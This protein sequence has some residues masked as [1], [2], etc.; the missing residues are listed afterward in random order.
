MSYVHAKNK[1]SKFLKML[2]NFGYLKLE[3]KI[4]NWNL[5]FIRVIQ[6]LKLA[7]T[8]LEQYNPPIYYHL[9]FY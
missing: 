7:Y 1:S 8:D 6:R 9:T 2:Y 5:R 4:I 3:K